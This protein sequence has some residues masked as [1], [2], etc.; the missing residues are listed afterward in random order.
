M[1]FKSDLATNGSALHLTC[2]IA[3]SSVWER[4]SSLYQAC[5]EVWKQL[6][7]VSCP[8]VTP[9]AKLAIELKAVGAGRDGVIQHGSTD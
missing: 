8:I 1:E 6:W 4:S 9:P 2:T 7:S 5:E 3:C